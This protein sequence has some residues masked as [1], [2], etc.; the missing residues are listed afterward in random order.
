MDEFRELM[1]LMHGTPHGVKFRVWYDPTEANKGLCFDLLLHQDW[2]EMKIQRGGRVYVSCMEPG[3]PK[4][5]DIKD[6]LRKFSVALQKTIRELEGMTDG[7]T[8]RSD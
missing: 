4:S 7:T 2:P 3:G 6:V 8:G 1:N 5:D